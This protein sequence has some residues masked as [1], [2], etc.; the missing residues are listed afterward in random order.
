MNKKKVLLILTFFVG[1][2]LCTIL[3]YGAS[4]RAKPFDRFEIAN[5]DFKIRVTGYH[6]S[7]LYALPGARYV[8]QSAAAD[9]DIWHE[10]MSFKADQAGPIR[11]DQI[12]FV[13][14]QVAYAFI[15]RYYM[16]TTDGGREWYAWDANKE[17]DSEKIMGSYNL[18]PTIEK[19]T[20][21][22]DGNGLM[23]LKQYLKDRGTGPQLQTSDYG[24]HWNFKY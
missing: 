16:V 7:D 6:E 24:R 9:S 19:I 17:L 12:R 5:S 15:D 3:L 8:F 4:Q 23:T 21:E 10:I 1:I 18:W 14:T 11:R 20:M 2:S 22:A 13:N